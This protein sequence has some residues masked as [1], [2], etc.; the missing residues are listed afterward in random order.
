MSETNQNQIFYCTSC[1]NNQTIRL[2]KREDG[3]EYGCPRC[4][5]RYAFNNSNELIRTA[6]TGGIGGQP[7][8]FGPGSS[9]LFKGRG[10]QRGTGFNKDMETQIDVLM[11]RTHNP[12]PL[13]PERNMEKRLE[14]F[15][16]QGE[17]DS[18]PYNLSLTE[19]NKLNRKKEIRRREKYYA[20]A[21]DRVDHNTVQYIKENFQPREDQITSREIA[22]ETR[23][24]HKPG[25]NRDV[26][27]DQVPDQIA[28]TR[29]HSIANNV[30][31]HGHPPYIGVKDD[32]DARDP[33]APK[34]TDMQNQLTTVTGPTYDTNAG[35]EE[36]LTDAS[37]EDFGGGTGYGTDTNLDQGN[38]LLDSMGNMAAQETPP[39]PSAIPPKSNTP[40]NIN[41]TSASLEQQLDDLLKQKSQRAPS[42]PYPVEGEDNWKDQGKEKSGISDNYPD[43][44]PEGA[45][46][47]PSMI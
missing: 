14:P 32:E 41:N 2:I 24:V 44:T 47:L 40:N 38:N 8:S 33:F 11:S 46:P 20:D 35:L 39:I 28:P 6:Q 17:E 22:L 26:R 29:R 27:E 5:S 36:W 7:S 9:P 37:K 19:R 21:A 25:V 1:V 10:K 30:I 31:T 13:D 42:L 18:I 34:L 3:Q 4:H 43:T 12:A 15:H 45:V 16:T 23:R